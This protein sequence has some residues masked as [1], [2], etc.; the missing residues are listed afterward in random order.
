[1]NEN[2][3]KEKCKHTYNMNTDLGLIKICNKCGKYLIKTKN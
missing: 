1:M 2:K 3:N